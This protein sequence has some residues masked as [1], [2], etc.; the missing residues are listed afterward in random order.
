VVPE[1]NMPGALGSRASLHTALG[2]RKEQ[3]DRILGLPLAR[4]ETSR[5]T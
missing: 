3:V 1:K 5:G 2:V 4:R